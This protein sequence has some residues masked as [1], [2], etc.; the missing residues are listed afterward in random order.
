MATKN[1]LT[2]DFPMFETL[3]K[4]LNEAGGNTLTT[5][6][7]NALTTSASYID[8]QLKA[9]IAPHR[10]TGT[11]E[12]SLDTHPNQVEWFGSNASVQVGFNLSDGGLPSLFLMYGTKVH[13]QPHVKP[14]KKLYNAVYGSR[15]KNQ[16]HKIQEEAF[17]SIVSKVMR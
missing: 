3:K 10:R 12:Q 5:A 13:G 17:L 6:V 15:V 11:V 9:A 8:S 2:L 16:V 14:D 7:E 4:Q 1:K